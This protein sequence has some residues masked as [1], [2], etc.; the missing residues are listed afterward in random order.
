MYF[1]KSRVS[2]VRLEHGDIRTADQWICW[3]TYSR[4]LIIWTLLSEL[5]TSLCAIVSGEHLDSCMSDIASSRTWLWWRLNTTVALDHS[6]F[7]P[8]WASLLSGGAWSPSVVDWKDYWT[9]GTTNHCR[10]AE[11]SQL[12]PRD[13]NLSRPPRWQWRRRVSTRL[14]KFS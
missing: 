7:L 2:S 11:R 1:V 4:A 12:T 5:C 13:R 3:K 10:P 8:T 14:V 9:F 6:A